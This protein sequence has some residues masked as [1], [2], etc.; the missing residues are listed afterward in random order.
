[1]CVSFNCSVTLSMYGQE[2]FI[3]VNLCNYCIPKYPNSFAPIVR[4]PF[5]ERIFFD[6]LY[7]CFKPVVIRRL[8]LFFL[9]VFIP[10]HSTMNL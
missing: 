5:G 4:K 8:V 1:M 6:E 7:F 10:Y 9:N 3:K 2:I